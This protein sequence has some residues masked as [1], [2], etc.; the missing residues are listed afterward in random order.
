MDAR[1]EKARQ[2]R[3]QEVALHRDPDIDKGGGHKG[4]GGKN[5]AGELAPS[6]E[7]LRSLS[8]GGL[9]GVG[10][11]KA[12]TRRVSTEPARWSMICWTAWIV[13]VGEGVPG[14]LKIALRKRHGAAPLRAAGA[15][16]WHRV[17]LRLLRDLR[18][19]VS[20][21][22]EP[23]AQAIAGATGTSDATTPAAG[24]AEIVDP[25]RCA[26]ATT[27]RCVSAINA[28]VAG[29]RAVA[30]LYLLATSDSPAQALGA[31]RER[32]LIFDEDA[33]AAFDRLGVPDTPPNKAWEGGCTGGV[34]A[35]GVPRR[36]G[37]F[38]CG[39]PWNWR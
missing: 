23:V 21:S 25:R 36:D 3:P 12:V 30:S 24:V 6:Y 32:Y 14:H 5:G 20:T 39:R 15:A 27:T 1:G 28:V 8:R 31:A 22:P 10:D 29:V 13:T 17:S 35:V 2:V 26:C 19:V 18:D 4:C 16:R 38:A 7:A 34:H 33:L 37:G 11:H 9:D